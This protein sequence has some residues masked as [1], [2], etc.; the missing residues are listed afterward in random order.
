[1]RGGFMLLLPKFDYEEP[2]SLPEA[3]AM[4]SELKGNGKVIAGG[5]DLLV[6][7]KKGTVK[8]AFLVS[9]R[10]VEGLRE[11]GGENGGL[12]IGSH[13]TVSEIADSDRV[14]SM[15]PVLARSASCLGSPLIRN[16][17][18]IGGNI[19][20]ARPAADLPPA[21]IV[22]GAYVELKGKDANRTIP[23]DG[24]FTGPGT[25][26]IESGEVLT[27]IILPSA[28]PFT[29]GDYIKIGHRAALEI[30]IVAAASRLT[31]DKPDGVIVDARVVLSA[32]APTA[33]HAAS[34]E[35]ALIG[36]RPSEELFAKAAALA[37]GDCSPITDMRGGAEYRRDMVNTLVKRTLLKAFNDA[38]DMKG[39]NA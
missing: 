4:L 9:L 19:V 38:R 18:T 30:A 16:R 27:R 37:E 28:P 20:T 29:G 31:L 11:I 5:T 10:K 3:L 24:F 21:L 7:M 32:V 35:K 6:N 22:L 23:L 1:M 26:V 36:Q 15:F 17:A 8:P 13:A 39:G 34:A 25:S 2:K 14:G 33:I 12:A